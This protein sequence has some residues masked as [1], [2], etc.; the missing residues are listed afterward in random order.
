MRRLITPK[1][2]IDM[3]SIE[4]SNLIESRVPFI[5]AEKIELKKIFIIALV[6]KNYLEK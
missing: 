2:F 1:E 6:E 4:I 3:T 5:V